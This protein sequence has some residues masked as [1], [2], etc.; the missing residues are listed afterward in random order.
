MDHEVSFF[1]FDCQ[2]L[3]INVSLREGVD[4]NRSFL[5]Q[6]CEIEGQLKFDEWAVCP[7]PA[8]SCVTKHNAESIQDTVQCGVIIRRCPRY[9][10]VNIIT[11]LCLITLLSFSPIAI[12]SDNSSTEFWMRAEVFLGIFPL[13]VIFKLSVQARLPRV[14]Y[15]TWFDKYANWAFRLF[16]FI[17]AY[18]VAGSSVSVVSSWHT[19][20]DCN[21]LLGDDDKDQAHEEAEFVRQIELYLA[22]VL[23]VLWI[24]YNI[25]FAVDALRVQMQHPAEVLQ[26]NA[27]LRLQTEDFVA[28]KCVE[29]LTPTMSAL[30]RSPQGRLSEISEAS[31]SESSSEH[32]TMFKME[33]TLARRST[34]QAPGSESW[35]FEDT[36]TPK[37]RSSHRQSTRSSTRS[38]FSGFSRDSWS[39]IRSNRFSMGN[40]ASVGRG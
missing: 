10:V 39:A 28:N 30:T 24:G 18:A 25:R 36:L 20:M 9:Y 4:S 34:C 33:S 35:F 23:A 31:E 27:P 38:S 3:M 40:R 8:F 29:P 32:P 6:Y 13:I 2:W 11:M 12:I 1:P 15:S 37:R 16:M 19:D 22:A 5:Y 21:S 7:Q 17:V 14:S 26:T